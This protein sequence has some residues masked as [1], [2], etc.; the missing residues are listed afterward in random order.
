MAICGGEASGTA[1]D[2]GG[3]P[4]GAERP[5]GAAGMP[6]G[7]DAASVAVGRTGDTVGAGSCPVDPTSDS[8]ATDDVGER[9][10]G[11]NGG[12]DSF[13]FGAFVVAG[14]TDRI[15]CCVAPAGVAGRDEDA[16]EGVFA[17]PVAVPPLR[18]LPEARVS[19]ADVLA[20]VD[21]DRCC[22]V[23][24][25]PRRGCRPVPREWLLVVVLLCRAV[26]ARLLEPLL[27]HDAPRGKPAGIHDKRM[28]YK[29]HRLTYHHQRHRP[30]Y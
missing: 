1:R 18:S 8:M 24:V 22:L 19:A 2:G 6:G 27:A 20:A 3:R 12:L 25:P 13:T 4:G 23:F 9:D 26:E 28:C 17:A 10:G 7:I 29:G 16:C 11:G 5:G 14:V 30:S 15:S 21:P